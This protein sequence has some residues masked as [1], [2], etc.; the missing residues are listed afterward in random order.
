MVDLVLKFISACRAS[1][2]R[3]STSE[4][5]DCL[6]HLDRI[7]CTC[8]PEFRAALRANFAKSIRE[9]NHFNHL[10]HLFFHELRLDAADM[11]QAGQVGE[12]IR[13][14]TDRLRQDTS[15]DAEYKTIVDF[16]AGDPHSLLQE[17]HR[18]RTESDDSSQSVKF[19]LTPLGGRLK[20]LMQI[21]RAGSAAD[22]LIRDESVGIDAPGRLLLAKHFEERLARAQKLLLFEPLSD[23]QGIKKSD[24]AGERLKQLG[25][26]PFSSFT[27]RETMEMREAIDVLVRKLQNI[28]SRRFAVRNRGGLDIKKTL[29][30]A[31]RYNGVPLDL[32]YRRKAIRR[33]RIVTLCDVSGSV[34]SAAHFMLNLLYSLQDC[35]D[36]VNSFVFVDRLTEV[37]E[38]FEEN[39]INE[40]IEI[41]LKKADVNYDATTDYGE[42]FRHFKRNSMD[43][44]TKK[45][46]LII[47]GDARS[48]YLN[49]ED[50]IL[51]E[52]RDRCRR[53]IWL[54][55]EPEAIWGTAD[56]EI[57][58]YRQYCHEV[59]PCRNLNQLISFIEELVM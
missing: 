29:R 20:I 26:K 56:S 37:T 21:V 54:N 47:V 17:L 10:Y 2:L 42:T 15:Q 59:R 5:L 9:L 40:A 31:A 53:L 45:T 28:S 13:K 34:W 46:T 50:A 14:V 49:P 24:D 7:D 55:P 58:N 1:G 11:D 6:R 57:Y 16:L 8:E 52:M 39:D 41:V 33:S 22:A 18:L 3:I 48:N 43:I 23:Q 51:G 27:A 12:Q 38:T 30:A 35:F 36:R 19:N 4:V 32:K 25:E 44:L